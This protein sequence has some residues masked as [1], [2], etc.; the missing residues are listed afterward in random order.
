VVVN[1]RFRRTP[2]PRAVR[3]RMTVCWRN[4]DAGECAIGQRLAQDSHSRC[5]NPLL[6]VLQDLF[7]QPDAIAMVT[8]NCAWFAK[9]W[10]F[11]KHVRRVG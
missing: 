7:H 5:W 3:L 9:L 6:R 8:G 1:G 2:A 4:A 10:K 11:R